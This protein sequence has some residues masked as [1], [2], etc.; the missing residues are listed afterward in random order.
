M[1]TVGS[2][3]SVVDA[4]YGNVSYFDG[5]SY[6]NLASG[7]VPSAIVGGSSRAFSFWAKADNGGIIHGNGTDSAHRRFRGNIN[8][9]T[10]RYDF[11]TGTATGTESALLGEWVHVVTTYEASTSLFKTYVNGVADISIVNA[12]INTGA[13]AL[14][15]GR[16]P[17]KASITKFIGNILD[18]RIY[19]DLIDLAAVT[20]LYSAGPLDMNLATIDA[21]MYTHLADLTWS[22][23]NGATNYT[24]NQTID[25]GT[26][27]TIVDESTDLLYTSFDLIPNSSYTFDLYT[28]LDLVT[29]VASLTIS[30]PI[31][32]SSSTT[33]LVTRL[34]NDLS[35]LSE[36]AL[37]DVDAF[38]RTAFT[39]GTV[40]TLSSGKYLFVEDSASIIRQ[41]GLGIMTPFEQTA[42]SSQTCTITTDSVSD[43]ITYDEISNEIT[44]A[45][46]VVS[47]G[48][49][50]ILGNKKVTMLEF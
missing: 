22:S 17:S 36:N 25:G 21:T 29:A 50:F 30:T 31:V 15:L 46:G 27:T 37:E 39:T 33:S 32:D 3:T 28:D 47:P 1:T 26:E 38:L 11:N 42:G 12:S 45:T 16:D 6:L 48:E 4:T 2:V 13:G 18:F 40:V 8:G 41:D 14:S 7:S 5:N 10:V 35:S 43:T 9:V 23:V 20:S 49:Y 24:V 19:N 44:S 34:S